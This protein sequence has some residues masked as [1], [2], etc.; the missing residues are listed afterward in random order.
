MECS[1]VEELRCY[2]AVSIPE[3]TTSRRSF[4]FFNA[5]SFLYCDRIIY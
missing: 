1:V 5:V 2:K 3:I 4:T